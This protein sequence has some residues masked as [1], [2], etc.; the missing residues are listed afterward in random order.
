MR[1]T[2]PKSATAMTRIMLLPI[3]TNPTY[4]QSWHTPLQNIVSEHPSIVQE[5]AQLA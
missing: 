3:V 5:L 2:P 4:L 1:T